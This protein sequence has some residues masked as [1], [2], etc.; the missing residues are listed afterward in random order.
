MSKN[1]GYTYLEIYNLITPYFTKIY[2]RFWKRNPPATERAR[3][4]SSLCKKICSFFEDT[5]SYEELDNPRLWREFHKQASSSLSLDSQRVFTQELNTILRMLY[6][7]GKIRKIRLKPPIR[8]FSSSEGFHIEKL[9]DFT[10]ED[11]VKLWNTIGKGDNEEF[12]LLF[13]LVIC[14]CTPVNHLINLRVSGIIRDSIEIRDR[15]LIC[16]VLLEPGRTLLLKYIIRNGLKK[17]DRIFG[18]ITQAAFTKWLKRQCILSSAPEITSRDLFYF[19]RFLAAI[20]GLPAYQVACLGS[21]NAFS[22]FSN[23]INRKDITN[24]F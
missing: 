6:E 18:D 7:D 4:F 19:A 1:I 17:G 20:Q 10:Y 12:T 11:I 13:I 24:E 3:K 22:P 2:K 23:I 14:S 5:K 16:S 9:L 8:K 15:G 21:K